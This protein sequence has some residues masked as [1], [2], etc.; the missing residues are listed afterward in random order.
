MNSS[1]RLGDISA[2]DLDKSHNISNENLKFKA[3][4]QKLTRQELLGLAR[5]PTK[6]SLSAGRSVPSVSSVSPVP[7]V[8][9]GRSLSTIP[10][11]SMSH[12]QLNNQP[13]RNTRLSNFI[14]THPKTPDYKW[15][16][17]APPFMSSMLAG[18]KD[19]LRLPMSSRA[20]SSR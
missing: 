2:A 11:S 17:P 5:M 19:E 20:S 1:Q 3:S 15:K 7:S 12:D 6:G 14:A 8:P 13:V 18:A 4:R 16:G 10:V 9:V